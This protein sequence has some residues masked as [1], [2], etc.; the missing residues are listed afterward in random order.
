MAHVKWLT[1][2]APIFLLLVFSSV[3]KENAA[4][5]INPGAKPSGLQ[6]SSICWPLLSHSISLGSILNG[7]VDSSPQNPR[8][9][10]KQSLPCE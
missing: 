1:V 2:M 6:H 7:I 3:A 9:E 4:A 8:G 10:Q 5:I